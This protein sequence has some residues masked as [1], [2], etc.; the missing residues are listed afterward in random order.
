MTVLHLVKLTWRR[1]EREQGADAMMD[2]A[3]GGPDLLEETEDP[4]AE[5]GEQPTLAAI[6]RA[7]NKCT[8]SVN[9]LQARFGGLKEKVSLIRQDIQKIMLIRETQSTTRLAR[10]TDMCAEDFENCLRLNNV[11][12]VGLPEKVESRYPMQF[13]EQWMA[14]VFGKEA[15][16]HLYAV[17]RA[18]REASPAGQSS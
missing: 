7:V 5:G 1:R 3:E 18:H 14:D 17:E 10:A 16:T 11:C 9:N 13:V 8:A 4:D 6:L 15:F 12:I 2:Q